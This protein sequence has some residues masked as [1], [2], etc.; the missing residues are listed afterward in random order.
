MTTGLPENILQFVRTDGPSTAPIAFLLF[1]Q[2]LTFLLHY[3]QKALELVQKV[4]PD[5]TGG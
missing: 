3:N 4:C 5:E 2:S 1:V